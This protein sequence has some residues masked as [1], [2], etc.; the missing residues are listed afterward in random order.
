MKKRITLEKFYHSTDACGEHCVLPYAMMPYADCELLI[1]GDSPEAH[2]ET[3]YLIFDAEYSVA[4][5]IYITSP[6]ASEIRLFE[7]EGGFCKI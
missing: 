7:G 3:W 1:I 6:N 5:G 2:G 4:R